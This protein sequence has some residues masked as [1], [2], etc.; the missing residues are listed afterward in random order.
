MISE[1]LESRGISPEKLAEIAELYD[2]HEGRLLATSKAKREDATGLPPPSG[3]LPRPWKRLPYFGK[4]GWSLRALTAWLAIRPNSVSLAF[5]AKVSSLERPWAESPQCNSISPR[6][7][8]SLYSYSRYPHFRATEM[9][10]SRFFLMVTIVDG[11]APFRV[12]LTRAEVAE[13]SKLSGRLGDPRASVLA[14]L[15]AACASEI[16]P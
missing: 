4:I 3:I 8:S 15:I 16:L 12:S 2:N 13:M 9:T 5:L 7:S 10:D 14:R 6:A 11:F 1:M